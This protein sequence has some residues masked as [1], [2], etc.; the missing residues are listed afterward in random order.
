M[1][2]RPLQLFGLEGRIETLPP[3]ATALPPLA[4]SPPPPPTP[5]HPPSAPTCLFVCQITAPS[6]SAMLYTCAKFRQRKAIRGSA[7]QLRTSA[8]IGPAVTQARVRARR[9]NTRR[10]NIRGGS[11]LSKHGRPHLSLRSRFPRLNGYADAEDKRRAVICPSCDF[12]PLNIP[13]R[14]DAEG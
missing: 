3:E 1:P 6:V 8:R 10:S 4:S 9:R 11:A 2:S 7:K 14:T 13:L 5:H 12:Q